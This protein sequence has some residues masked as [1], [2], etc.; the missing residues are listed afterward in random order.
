MGEKVGKTNTD[1]V[2]VCVWVTLV[3]AE[4]PKELWGCLC[5]SG[6]QNRVYVQRPHLNLIF[7]VS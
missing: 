3:L 6:K 4:G 7:A 2:A 5:S 1:E